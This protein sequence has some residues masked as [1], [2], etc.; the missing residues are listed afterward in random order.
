MFVS[1]T[2]IPVKI[3]CGDLHGQPLFLTSSVGPD[4]LN[5]D[6]F[7][8]SILCILYLINM[9]SAPSVSNFDRFPW[10]LLSFIEEICFNLYDRLWQI[11]SLNIFSQ[12]KSN[13]NGSKEYEEIIEERRKCRLYR[14]FKNPFCMESL[15]QIVPNG[16]FRPCIFINF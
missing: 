12:Q 16:R 6:G 14:M 13:Q 1:E 11:S 15:T 3:K 5:V 10:L 8:Y 7:I 2:E 9:Y 4:Q